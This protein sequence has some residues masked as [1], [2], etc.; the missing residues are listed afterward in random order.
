VIELGCWIPFKRVLKEAGVEASVKEIEV[1][2]VKRDRIDE[3]I[4][5]Y[6]GEQARYGHCSAD[7]RQVKTAVKTNE[8][9]RNKL[10]EG[11][12]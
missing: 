12:K 2:A 7:W 9:L 5:Q 10:V 4:H 6:M 3:I 8:E 1:S 11:L